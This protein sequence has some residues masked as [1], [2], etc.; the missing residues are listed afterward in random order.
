MF[1]FDLPDE[2]IQLDW[3]KK[4]VFHNVSFAVVET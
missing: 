2:K 4:T 3:G 1:H